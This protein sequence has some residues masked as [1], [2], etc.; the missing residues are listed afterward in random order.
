VDIMNLRVIG[1]LVVATA[2]A[3][4]IVVGDPGDAGNVAIPIAVADGAAGAGSNAIIVGDPGGDGPGPKVD[5]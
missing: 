4:A 3:A 5:H 2:F 1:R